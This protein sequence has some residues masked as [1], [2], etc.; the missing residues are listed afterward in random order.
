PGCPGGASPRIQDRD[1]RPGAKSRIMRVLRPS[2][3]PRESPMVSARTPALSATG[4]VA[5]S[6]P[7]AT[8]AGVATL[9]AGGSA[10]DAALAANAVLAVAEP[11]MC[12]PGGDLFALV[13][14]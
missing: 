10:L 7:C 14:D 9:A 2:R 6:Q 3:R 11:H 12:G 13:W 1:W 4:M 8:R 5:T